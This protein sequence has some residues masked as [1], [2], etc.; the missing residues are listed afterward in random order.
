[1]RE[2]GRREREVT[3]RGRMT[4]RREGGREA[5]REG[6][7]E[8]GREG[9]RYKRSRTFSVTLTQMCRLINMHLTLNPKP[10]TPNPK[11]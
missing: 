7:R 9:E 3:E 5:G 8:R 2:E 10:Q 6:G 11:P 1:V 4:G